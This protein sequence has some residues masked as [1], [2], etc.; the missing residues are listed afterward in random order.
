MEFLH[1]NISSRSHELRYFGVLS[2]WP[3][4][5]FPAARPLGRDLLYVYPR[6][7]PWRCHLKFCVHES[8]EDTFSQFRYQTL[9]L[10]RSTRCLKYHHEPLLSCVLNLAHC[11]TVLDV[12]GAAAAQDVTNWERYHW[13]G[14]DHW[15]LSAGNTSQVKQNRY[16][17]LIALSQWS[18]FAVGNRG[19]DLR[20]VFFVFFFYAREDQ[21]VGNGWWRGDRAGVTERR[22]RL[23]CQDLIGLD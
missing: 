21:R 7:P 15:L 20:G 22:S 19:V 14:V 8:L 12:K 4:L 5:Q 10:R 13:R 23:C 9:R 6:H 2:V 16:T 11:S 17:L 3:G 1:T 18:S